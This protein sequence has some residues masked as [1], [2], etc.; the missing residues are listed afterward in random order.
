MPKGHYRREKINIDLELVLNEVCCNKTIVDI[1]KELGINRNTIYQRLDKVGINDVQQ[2]KFNHDFFE[3][4]DNEEK[5]YWLGFFMADGCVSKSA[6]D[7]AVL[8]LAIVDENHIKKWL[9][10]LDSIQKPCIFEDNGRRYIAS[11]H[12]STKMCDDLVKL[13]CTERKSLTL[14]FPKLREDLIRHFI[15]GYLDGD[16]C[17]H[18]GNK[19]QKIWQIKVNLIGTKPFLK[20]IQK[21]IGVYTKMRRIGNKKQNFSF[22]I[23]GNKQA[24][25][26]LDWLYQDATIYLDRKFERYINHRLKI[27]KAGK[28]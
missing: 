27:K 2:F 5:A 11:T 28:K 6:T 12:Y 16:G 4:I 8:K 15:R 1:A 13:G 23:D 9:R 24:M 3:K 20:S 26:I 19:N 21:I 18:F 7:K 22:N 10:S 25:R 17:I 14:E